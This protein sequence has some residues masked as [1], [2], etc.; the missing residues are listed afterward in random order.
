MMVVTLTVLVGCLGKDQAIKYPFVTYKEP[1]QV[2]LNIT[3]GSYNSCEKALK[4]ELIL[5]RQLRKQNKEYR[6]QIERY[7]DR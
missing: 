7:N 1:K 3:I 5:I 2:E 4:E 6:K